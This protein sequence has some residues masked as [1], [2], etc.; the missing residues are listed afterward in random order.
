MKI[1]E[2]WLKDSKVNIKEYLSMYEES[3][4]QN[5]NFWKTKIVTFFHESVK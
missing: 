2:E 3:L 1:K 4:N 5:D